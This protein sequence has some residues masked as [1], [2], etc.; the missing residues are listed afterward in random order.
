MLPTGAVGG[1][2]GELRNNYSSSTVMESS[3]VNLKSFA[4]TT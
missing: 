3:P 2:L 1:E 4:Y